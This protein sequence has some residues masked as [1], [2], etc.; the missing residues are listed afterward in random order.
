[1]AHKASLIPNFWESHNISIYE[2]LA[3]ISRGNEGIPNWIEDFAVLLR[4]I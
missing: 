4:N 2:S 1:M 3:M